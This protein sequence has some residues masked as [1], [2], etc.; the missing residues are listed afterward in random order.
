[1]VIFKLSNLT[2][3]FASSIK[4]PYLVPL[5]P[6]LVWVERRFNSTMG[7]LITVAT[8]GLS[9]SYRWLYADSYPNSW[10]V[11]NRVH[12]SNDV[13]ATWSSLNQ[14]ALD[15]QVLKLNSWI[16]IHFQIFPGQLW[17]YTGKHSDREESR[18]QAEGRARV[19]DSVSNH[20]DCPPQLSDELERRGYGCL[21]HFL[22]GI[23][24]HPDRYYNDNSWYR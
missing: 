24:Y 23:I 6:R 14:W 3:G 18:C 12:N 7:H 9:S 19:G 1:M 21:D 5:Q 2:C 15:F 13:D 8:W 17:T 16:H 4:H 20:G 10:Y 22:E 11:N